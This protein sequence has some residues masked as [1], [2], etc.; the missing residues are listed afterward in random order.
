MMSHTVVGNSIQCWGLSKAQ[1][2]LTKEKILVL[3]ALARFVI[4]LLCG[5]QGVNV[6]V[7][8]VCLCI[9]E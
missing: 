4:L 5:G 8:V 9:H 1:L 6:Y 7:L 2:V 3:E